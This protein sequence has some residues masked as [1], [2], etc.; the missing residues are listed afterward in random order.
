MSAPYMTNVGNPL[1]PSFCAT[2][3]AAVPSTT[4]MCTTPF[5]AFAASLTAGADDLQCPHHGAYTSTSQ[6]PSSLSTK[7]AGCRRE[8]A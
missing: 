7:E 8:R 4:P 2:A 5:S 3:V 6:M 1:T